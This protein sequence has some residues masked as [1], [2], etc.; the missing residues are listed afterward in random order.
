MSAPAAGL[1]T[2]RCTLAAPASA[3]VGRPLPLRLTL[4]NIGRQTVHVLTWGTP[5][6]GWLSPFVTVQQGGEALVYGGAA[7]KRGEP[8]ADDYLAI[9]PGRSRQAVVDLAEVFDLRQPG[10][11]HVLPRIVLHD[12]LAGAPAGVPLPRPRALHQSAALMC[13]P[14]DIKLQPRPR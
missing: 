12:W 7:L 9:A 14:V 8:G 13:N 10:H 11:L 5:F 2:L 6:E 1:P 3:T 4:H